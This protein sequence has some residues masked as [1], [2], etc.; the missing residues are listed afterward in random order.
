M[1]AITFDDTHWPLL[2]LRFEGTP[3]PEQLEAYLA[4]RLEYLQRQERHGIVYDTRQAR[5]ITS[6]VR[7]R[8]AA[9]SRE[10]QAQRRQFLVGN[11][12]IIPSP[13]IRLSMNLVLSLGGAK[14]PYSVAATVP[15]GALWVAH[16]LH[17]AGETEPAER[18]RRHFEPLAQAPHSR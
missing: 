5:L 15:E 9:W 10:H 4:R 14:V 7:Q 6:Q 18:L 3:T 1:S 13:V 11:A 16:R 2:L 17:E 12:L 8:H